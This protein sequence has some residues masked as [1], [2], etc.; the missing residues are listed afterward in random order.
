MS[1]H[2]N[3]L[4][5]QVVVYV[6]SNSPLLDAPETIDLFKELKIKNN[7]VFLRQFDE[8]QVQ[9]NVALHCS[10]YDAIV[11][12]DLVYAAWG[13]S[14]RSYPIWTLGMA[15]TSPR[16]EWA[17]PVLNALRDATDKQSPNIFRQMSQ[18]LLA[19]LKTHPW[20]TRAARTRLGFSPSSLNSNLG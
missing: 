11:A 4:G 14:T 1:R 2:S 10:I 16:A 20:V 9:V 8:P 7:V 12:A 17:I 18:F 15:S 5:G 3:H 6:Y 19:M 13:F